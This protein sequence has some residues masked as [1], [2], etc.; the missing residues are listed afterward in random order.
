M[1]VEN[2]YCEEIEQE[3]GLSGVFKKIELCGRVS[4]KSEDKITDESS[5]KFVNRLI[6][7]NH[8][9]VLEHGNI[10][11]KI[12]DVSKYPVPARAIHPGE[13][14]REELS[15]RGIDT[16][17]FAKQIDITYLDSLLNCEHDIDNDLSCKLE[18]YLGIPSDVWMNLQNDY[19]ND[20]ISLNNRPWSKLIHNEYTKVNEHDGN[21]YI[22]TNY[23]VCIENHLEDCLKYMCEPIKYHEKRYTFRIITSIDISRELN[24]HRKNSITEQSTRYCNFSKNK[25]NHEITFIESSESS[26]SDIFNTVHLLCEHYYMK[27]I[28]NGCKPEIARKVLTLDTKTEMY[29]T[30]FESDWYNFLHLRSRKYG[31]RTAHVDASLIADKIANILKSKNIIMQKN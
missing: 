29:H 10:Y 31:A 16:K 21:L 25:F 5:T 18:K 4:Y 2:A 12:P 7:N 13:V 22:S 3:S 1:K 24:R 20:T 14:L 11:L 27:L 26:N 23:R 8:L 17:D 28:D 30:A 9:S 6:D 15:E 19:I